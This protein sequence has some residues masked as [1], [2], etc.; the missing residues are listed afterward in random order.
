[1]VS[2]ICQDEKSLEKI[3]YYIINLI[4]NFIKL[5]NKYAYI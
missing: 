4:S 2:A 3:F 1:M 5:E